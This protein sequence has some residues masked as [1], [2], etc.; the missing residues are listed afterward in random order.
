[1][2]GLMQDRPLLISSILAFADRHHGA[3][4]I[5]TKLVEGETLACPG[6]LHRYTYREA[7]VR[8][9]ALA[10]ALKALGVQAADRV[11][12]L[13]WNSYRHFELYYA[14]SGLGAILHT[15]NPRLFPD[16]LAWIATDADDMALFFDLSF[17]GLV[18]QLAPRLPNIRHFVLL[19]GRP[20]FPAQ[21]SLPGLLCYDDLIASEPAR[22][23]TWPV[24]DENTAASLCYTSGTTG[25]PKG[26]LYSHRS[27]ILHAFGTALP[28]S[29]A[30]SSRDA[31]MPVVPMFHA[32][33]WGLV[34]SAPLVGAR[35]VLPGKDLDGPSLATL[36]V[37]EQVTVS[38]GVP[39]VWLGLLAHW[40]AHGAPSML[41]SRVLVG[42]AACPPS[43]IRDFTRLGVEAIHGWGMTEMSPV[44]TLGTLKAKHRSCNDDERFAVQVKQG[45][46][47]F[48]VDMKVVDD[49]GVEL[50]WD[51][52]TF[53]HLLVRGPA[54]LRQY[55]K[56]DDS[57][58][59][60][61]WFPTG[62]VATIDPDGYM[63]ITDRSKDVIKS[64]GEWISSI[65]LENIAV[66]HPAVA[67]AACIGLRHEHWGERPVLIVVPK[68]GADLTRESV[69]AFFEG[70]VAKWWVP[71]DV[72]FVDELPHTATGKL[73]KNRLR[74][75]F[76]G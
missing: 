2:F 49:H 32:N 30:L 68:P 33:A 25:H 3:T 62:D 73:Q 72:R 74:E 5:V 50:P 39:T 10:H 11:A 31:V 20:E 61:G 15:L 24:F 64:G 54:V 6:G 17:L 42:G 38:A 9:Q 58:L 40:Q 47:Y 18:E 7:H 63:Q 23:F 36:I 45:R 46:S 41:L 4:E 37:N 21:T 8:T 57:P 28:D 19:C 51:G 1:M 70:K 29:M 48:G 52:R 53:G 27:T 44:G 55:Y 56:T 14:V 35:L 66:G 22:Q 12:T 13:A 26:V 43:M 69:L 76:G 71:D 65:E 34:Y 67:E 59:V 60:D 75:S 16:Q